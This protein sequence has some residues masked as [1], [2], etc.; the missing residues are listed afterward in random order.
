MDDYTARFRRLVQNLKR[1]RRNRAGINIVMR[2]HFGDVW[3]NLFGGYGPMFGS[4]AP[5]EGAPSWQTVAYW[6]SEC[7]SDADYMTPDELD[8]VKALADQEVARLIAD[9]TPLSIRSFMAVVVAHIDSAVAAAAKRGIGS[10]ID[11]MIC[12]ER[13][14][15]PQSTRAA[16]KAAYADARRRAAAVNDL[17]GR[18][19]A[20]RRIEGR[21]VH[22]A[23]TAAGRDARRRAKLAAAVIGLP[24]ITLKLVGDAL[25]A[26]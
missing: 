5:R 20:D 12:R 16:A 2:M 22:K 14:A 3:H 4:D 6:W 19:R 10:F 11:L 17:S 21:R 15:V 9:G 1:R 13:R 8:V 26:R 23:A 18:T 25:L 7:Y 24:S